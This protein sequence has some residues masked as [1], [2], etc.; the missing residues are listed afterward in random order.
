MIVLAKLGI[1]MK[2][3]LKIGIVLDDWKLEIFK[4]VLS[5]A[6]Y[7]YVQVAGVTKN[8]IGLMIE[9]TNLRKL[10][11]VVRKANNRAAKSKKYH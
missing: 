9:T 4:E 1:K 8:T 7:K 11:N 6:G 3:L 5:A 2:K 10:Q